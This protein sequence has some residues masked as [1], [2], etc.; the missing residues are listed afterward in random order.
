MGVGVNYGLNGND[1]PAP[2]DV[3]KLLKSK[4]ITKVR[5]YDP[6]PQVLEALRGSGIYV[7]LGT[8]NADIPNF[9]NSVEASVSW[10][11]TNIVPY[12]N[13]V[14]IL[15]VTV[16]NEVVGEDAEMGAQVVPAMRNLVSALSKLGL[17]NIVVT[18]VVSTKVLGQTYPPSSGIFK[19]QNMIDVVKFLDAEKLPLMINVYPYFALSSNPG[20]VPLEFALF[21][22]ST[23][24]YEDQGLPY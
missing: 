1:L 8:R 11:N 21:T 18:T 23:P 12:W 24:A 4:G 16:G 10:A 7:T 20:D 3:V 17:Q 2:N 9:A 15:W 14:E 19:D 5:I 22:A 6:N 13:N